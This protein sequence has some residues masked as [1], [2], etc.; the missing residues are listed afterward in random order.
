M[1]N[2][3]K[4]VGMTANYTE[5]RPLNAFLNIQNKMYKY[6]KSAFFFRKHAFNNYTIK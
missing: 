3:L 2:K 1:Q 4:S 6:T 5:K